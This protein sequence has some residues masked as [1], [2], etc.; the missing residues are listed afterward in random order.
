VTTD[1]L[2]E[3]SSSS[4]RWTIPV[5]PPDHRPDG[6]VCGVCLRSLLPRRA[7]WVHVLPLCRACHSLNDNRQVLAWWLALPRAKRRAMIVVAF[8]LDPATVAEAEVDAE[9]T[10][11]FEDLDGL[12]SGLE[13]RTGNHAFGAGEFVLPVATFWELHR[14]RPSAFH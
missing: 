3:P 14:D 13:T 5:L 9:F 11:Y 10:R 7:V 8:E 4:Y 2:P 1:D 6:E 12:P